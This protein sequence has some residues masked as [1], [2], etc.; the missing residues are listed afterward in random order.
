MN[1][2]AAMKNQRLYRSRTN[3]VLAGV[4]GGYAEYFDVD[5]VIIRI[6]FVLL[7]VFG[8]SGIL[9]YIASVFIVPK[10][11]LQEIP[12]QQQSDNSSAAIA[13]PSSFRYLLGAILVVVGIF[14]L[15]ENLGFFSL[16]DF[17]DSSLEYIFPILLIIAGMAVIYHKQNA[18]Q[19]EFDSGKTVDTENREVPFGGSQ[20][21]QLR[22]SS[23][24]KKIAGVCGG[25]AQ[26]FGIDS[27]IVRVLYIILC[28]ASFGAGVLLYIILALVVPEDG[29]YRSQ[30]K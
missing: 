6:L 21:N 13:S 30:S 3:K 28:L 5:P 11:P 8:G 10:R 18:P 26:Y 25:L 4:C 12:E 1:N 15:I 17:L 9:L 2:E 27:S 19:K 29:V 7:T 20:Y 23:S 22:R 24:D 16:S 14:L